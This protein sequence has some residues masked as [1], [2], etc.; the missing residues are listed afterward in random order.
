MKYIFTSIPKLIKKIK[1]KTTLSEFEKLFLVVYEGKI[2]VLF[3]DSTIKYLTAYIKNKNNIEVTFYYKECFVKLNL[4]EKSVKYYISTPFY[5]ISRD[6]FAL[7]G[8]IIISYSDKTL[9][10]IIFSIKEKIE[11]SSFSYNLS[12]NDKVKYRL[13]K[14]RRK[15]IKNFITKKTVPTIILIILGILYYLKINHIVSILSIILGTILSISY[16]VDIIK[17]FISLINI[18]KDL[19]NKEIEQFTGKMTYYKRYNYSIFRTKG[20]INKLLVYITKVDDTLYI[21]PYCSHFFAFLPFIN[22]SES[23]DLLDS[24]KEFNFIYCKYTKLCINFELDYLNDVFKYR[25]FKHYSP[26]YLYSFTY[27]Y[28]NYFSKYI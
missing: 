20:L 18:Y 17:L 25:D 1:Q 12:F 19:K 14:Y 10:T 5:L 22:T 4:K 3:K 21:I 9:D 11:K 6:N 8:N 28:F 26:H 23:D 7:K 2:K 15:E 24:Q 27:L 13:K 16:V